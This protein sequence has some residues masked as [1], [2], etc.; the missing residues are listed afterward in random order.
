MAKHQQYKVAARV[1]NVRYE[2]STTVDLP[3][4]PITYAAIN[5]S[6]VEQNQKFKHTKD[7]TNHFTWSLKETIST[8]IP[9]SANVGVPPGC[10]FTTAMSTEISFDSP[11]TKTESE[12]KTWE[13]DHSPVLPP[14]C[15]IDITWTI[16]EKECSGTFYADI[17]L[18]G[19]FAIWTKDKVDINNPSGSDK[20]RLWFIPVD[21]AFNQMKDFGVSVPP[22]YTVGAGSVTYRASGECKGVSGFNTEFSMAQSQTNN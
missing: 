3:G 1:S 11:Q 6:D 20:R 10:S 13:T 14:H 19:H 2:D 16:K 8:G 22:L 9:L 5:D 7:T 17:I 21:E 15:R 12:T 18:T 4:V